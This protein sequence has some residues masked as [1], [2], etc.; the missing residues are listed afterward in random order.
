M[1]NHWENTFEELVHEIDPKTL[2]TQAGKSVVGFARKYCKTMPPRLMETCLSSIRQALSLSTLR[3]DKKTKTILDI[4]DT[5]PFIL[6][7]SHQ[8]VTNATAAEK[9]SAQLCFLLTRALTVEENVF[10][11]G[12]VTGTGKDRTAVEQSIR[13]GY[14]AYRADRRSQQTVSQRIAAAVQAVIP[15][16]PLT[17]A[18]SDR[19][20]DW[21]TRFNL[22]DDQAIAIVWGVAIVCSSDPE[23]DRG[24]YF[25]YLIHLWAR[26]QEN[27]QSRKR[28]DV[29]SFLSFE[30]LSERWAT[31]DDYEASTSRF[32]RS[33][34]ETAEGVG[35][36]AATG[37]GSSVNMTT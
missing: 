33:S 8:T 24:G 5:L 9:R 15:Y 12:L 32:T 35:F 13:E 6:Y 17:F 31:L 20:E 2:K 22:W 16:S 14:I 11:N 29:K 21:F 23:V 26:R 27:Q 25:L 4:L 34:K 19:L 3:P 10:G 7:L 28:Y 36:L 37:T 30:P 18:H 1:E